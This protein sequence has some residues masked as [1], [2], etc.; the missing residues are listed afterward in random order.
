MPRP[1]PEPGEL[2]RH[3]V[4]RG[5]TS[6]SR[7]DCAAFHSACEHFYGYLARWMGVAGCDA[8][9][10]RALSITQ[11]AHPMLERLQIQSDGS[12]HIGGVGEAVRAAGAEATAAALDALLTSLLEQLGRF[13]GLD[14][15]ATIVDRAV[16]DRAAS[17]PKHARERG[18]T[19]V[20]DRS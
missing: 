11:R 17:D 9:F 6:S 1:T 13:I 5:S 15:V 19:H 12:Q 8:L 2:T 4:E 20:G 3:L 7:S 14:L 10:R 16:S 18:S